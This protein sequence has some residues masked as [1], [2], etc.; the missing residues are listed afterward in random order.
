M[1]KIGIIFAMNEELDE[2]LKLVKLDKVSKVYDLSF[3]ECS[4][5]NKTCILVESGVGKV[6]SSRSTQ[7]LIDIYKPDYILNIGVAGGIDT[8]LNVGDIVVGDKLVQYDF[9]ITAFE[10]PCGYVPKVGVYVLCDSYLKNIA[11]SIDKNNVYNGIIATGDS[12]C[13]DGSTANRIRDEFKAIAVEMEGASI[14]MTA[15]LCNVPFLVI[16]AISDV[17]SKDNIISYDKFLKNSSMEVA[18]FTFDI[19]SKL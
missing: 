1:N 16:R 19:I 18:N 14:G 17:I 2:M 10:H 5:G 3:Y 13:T 11:L 9:D 12:F 8:K 4:I 6:N 15:Y 7:A